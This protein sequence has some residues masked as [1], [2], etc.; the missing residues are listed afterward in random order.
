MKARIIIVAALFFL[1]GVVLT[2]LT[3]SPRITKA[4]ELL[5]KGDRT[6]IIG[7]PVTA[8]RAY[9]DAVKEW[10]LIQLDGTYKAQLAEIRR[11]VEIHKPQVT[12]FLK[13]S[14][15]QEDISTLEAEIAKIGGALSVKYISKQEALEKF[16]QLNK[17]EPAL[18]KLVTPDILPA[19][20]SV[21]TK[22]D[23]VKETVKNEAKNKPFV[24]SVIV[25]PPL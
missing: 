13:N 2:I 17:N 10:P 11:D 18:L 15:S 8:L 6:K 14:A 7:K 12:I 4:T 22:D 25:S 23:N 9:E 5:A 19:S 16:K 21:S 20:I 24:E 1:L 3:I